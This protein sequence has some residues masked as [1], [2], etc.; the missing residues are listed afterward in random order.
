MNLPI[1]TNVPQSSAP[2][3]AA[4]ATQ[5]APDD[6]ASQAAAPFGKV[7]AR[8]L[9][10]KGATTASSADNTSSSVADGALGNISS[11]KDSK[12]QP[13]A[14]DATTTPLAG[15]L[16]ALHIV[17]P[18]QPAG[19][20]A[21]T[22]A[23]DGKQVQ[24]SGDKTAQPALGKLQLGQ[25]A[26]AHSAIAASE[27]HG[28]TDKEQFATA[29]HTLSNGKASAELAAQRN[30]PVPVQTD[31][32]QAA[33]AQAQLAQNNPLTA[34]ASA[35]L[36]VE[37]PVS[38]KD[39]GDNFSQKI[40][41]LST[42]NQ[43]SA[44]LHLNPPDLGPLKVVLQVSGD[45]ATAMFTSAHAAVRDAVEQAMPRLREMMADNGIMLGNATVSDHGQRDNPSSQSNNS[46]GQSPALSGVSGG[47][48][49]G[50]SGISQGTRVIPANRHNGM[51]DTFA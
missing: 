47:S 30:A 40:T 44:E 33:A 25:V 23:K 22:I 12:Q 36:S 32:A 31:A 28:V 11:K 4:S 20:Q 15:M 43:Q 19:S 1:S 39:W 10:D 41:W 2:K 42:Q 48:G 9:S 14:P 26:T 49:S 8:Q 51:V 46:R 24:L 17:P 34:S 5:Q 16:A 13:A 21:T 29:L 45:Q 50:I 18:A 7:L 37:T 38:S 35:S 6:Q 27:K 3:G